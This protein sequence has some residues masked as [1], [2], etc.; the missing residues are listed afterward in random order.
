MA[1][2]LGAAGGGLCIGLTVFLFVEGDA[3]W[4]S[5]PCEVPQWPIVVL[6]L[7]GGLFGSLFDSL[8]GATLQA[9]YYNPETKKITK[10]KSHAS[11][12]LISGLPFLS[13]DAV[14]FVANT[15]TAIVLPF[16]ARW[17]F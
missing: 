4:R 17:F 5:S 13:N 10:T 16:M 11:T 7:L 6:G 1:G 3:L 12:K 14:N 9:S 8:L 15:T 2:L